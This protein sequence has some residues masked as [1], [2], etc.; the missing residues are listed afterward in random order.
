MI[1]TGVGGH[2]S[3]AHRGADGGLHGHTWTVKA[4]FPAG[5][6][7]VALRDRLN[8][9]LA[10]FD[11]KE[12][13]PGMTLGEQLAEEIGR[14]LPGCV[15]VEMAREPEQIFARWQADA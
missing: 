8:A 15:A 1:L 14:S 12:L 7:A 11:H 4:W 5:D 2:I 13:P 10:R 3:A 9:V 6:D